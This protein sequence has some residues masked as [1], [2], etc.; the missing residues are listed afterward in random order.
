MSWKPTAPVV[1]IAGEQAN[2]LPVLFDDQSVAIMFDLVEPIV[3]VGTVVP[4]I[5]MQGSNAELRM[6]LRQAQR[7]RMQVR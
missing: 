7:R 6:R 2:A 4:R 1:A 3:P 5:G